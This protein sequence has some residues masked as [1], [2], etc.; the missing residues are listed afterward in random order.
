MKLLRLTLG[1]TLAFLLCASFSVAATIGINHVGP[2]QGLVSPVTL[3]AG[4]V[5]Q[6]NWNNIEG[7]SGSLND[8]IDGDGNVTDFYYLQY[9]HKKLP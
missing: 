1:F 9:E 3:E 5:P 4:V 6:S 7:A 8:L 2:G